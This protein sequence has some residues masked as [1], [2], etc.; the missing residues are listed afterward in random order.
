MLEHLGVA[1][2]RLLTN[3]PAK[4]A[5]LRELGVHVVGRTPIVVAPNPHSAPYL[6]A[7]RL[8]MQHDLPVELRAA[9]A[10]AE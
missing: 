8:R 9:G 2:V 5:A 1:S 3:N 7:K 4:V 6:E 10:D